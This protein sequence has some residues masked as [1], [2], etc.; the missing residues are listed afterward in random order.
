MELPVTE[1]LIYRTAKELA[2]A[3]AQQFATLAE[4]A[5]AQRGIF[6]VVLS[7]G[8]TPRQLYQRLVQPPYLDGLDWLNIHVFFGDERCVPPEHPDSNYG[9]ANE[10]LLSH[11]TLPES[12]IHRM[13]GELPAEQAA[14]T[15]AAE[16]HAIFGSN[17]PEFDLVLLGLGED[18]HIASLFPGAPALHEESRWVVAVAHTAPP[19]PL[20]PRLTLTLPVLNAARNVVFLVS[21]ENKS[22]ILANVLEEPAGFQQL[23]AQLVQPASGNLL[24]LVDQA[25][26]QHVHT[27]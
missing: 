1:L 19:P 2:D 8:N 23:P 21:G 27:K 15:Y 3:G 20:L 5:V 16:L 11:V 25:A 6:N 13:P 10:A 24:F 26:V 7:G 4:A 17:L 9:M 18:G 14:D 22:R 12:N